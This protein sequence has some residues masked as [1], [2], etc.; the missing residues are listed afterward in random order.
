MS[1]LGSELS[2]S[3]GELDEV[4]LCDDLQDICQLCGVISDDAGLPSLEFAIAAKL[5]ALS[6]LGQL[7]IAPY[8]LL[9]ARIACLTQSFP[10]LPSLGPAPFGVHDITVDERLSI[11]AIIVDKAGTSATNIGLITARLG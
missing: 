4:V 3:R 1:L 11:S 6:T 2:E 7:W 8:L 5:L 9:S 10:W